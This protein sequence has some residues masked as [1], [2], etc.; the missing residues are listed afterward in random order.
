MAGATLDAAANVFQNSGHAPVIGIDLHRRPRKVVGPAGV[1]RLDTDEI[2][3]AGSE[4]EPFSRTGVIRPA[5]GH[6]V[7]G[8]VTP[9]AKLGER[10]GEVRPSVTDDSQ[11]RHVAYSRPGRVVTYDAAYRMHVAAAAFLPAFDESDLQSRALQN[12]RKPR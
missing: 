4:L 6:D 11:T 1:F 7:I 3:I 5:R 9:E 10:S 2:G 8:T 12:I